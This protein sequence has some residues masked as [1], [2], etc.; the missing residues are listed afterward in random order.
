MTDKI[1]EAV[2]ALQERIGGNVFDGSAKFLIEDEGSIIVDISGV[3]A[4]NDATDVTLIASAET[5]EKI[6]EGVL[7]PTSAFMEGTLRVEGD[8][9]IAMKL[10]SL[11]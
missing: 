11:F 10:S 7:D 1:E 2:K 8:M 4:A 9:G 5:F 6:L 3:R